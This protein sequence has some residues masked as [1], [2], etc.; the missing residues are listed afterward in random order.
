M[1]FSEKFHID[2]KKGEGKFNYYFIV[3]GK[4]LRLRLVF[5]D[6]YEAKNGDVLRI[7]RGW[8]SHW[9]IYV[10]D[11]DGAYV[12]HYTTPEGSGGDFKGVVLKTPV[13]KFL[14]GSKTCK[15]MTKVIEKKYPN[16]FSGDETAQRAEENIGMAGYNFFSHNCEHF[17]KWCKAGEQISSNQANIFGKAWDDVCDFFDVT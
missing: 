4:E 14:E 6:G 2:K 8:Y 12:I 15:N 7:S 10:I 11:S 5:S 17:A 1:R 3:K 9:G 16:C 13:E